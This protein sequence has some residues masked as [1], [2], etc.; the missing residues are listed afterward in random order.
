MLLCFG[1]VR[2]GSVR[3]CGGKTKAMRWLPT[4]SFSPSNSSSSSSSSSSASAASAVDHR[5]KAWLFGNS[6]KKRACHVGDHDEDALVSSPGTPQQLPLPELSAAAVLRQQDGECRLPSPKD[7][8]PTTTGFRMRRLIFQFS[9]C[10]LQPIF[11]KCF[12]IVLGK[13]RSQ[14]NYH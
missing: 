6:S 2:F 13:L 14:F 7:A 11:F 4:L 3:F 5:R 9:L 1:L 12:S 10:F 8:A